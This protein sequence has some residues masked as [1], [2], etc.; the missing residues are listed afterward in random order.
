MKKL[1]SIIGIL[2]F[3][4]ASFADE[5]EPLSEAD[6]QNILS[7]LEHPLIADCQKYYEFDAFL[8]VLLNGDLANE[9]DADPASRLEMKQQ[10]IDY[11]KSGELKSR[12]SENVS[13]N[14]S[15]GCNSIARGITEAQLM[16]TKLVVGIAAAVGEAIAKTF[17]EFGKTLD[18]EVDEGLKTIPPAK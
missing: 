11:L 18:G 16:K 14:I 2:V 8:Q 5:I 10:F 3:G 17:E 4:A 6:Q 9:T 13:E 1:I 7:R 15:I 12:S